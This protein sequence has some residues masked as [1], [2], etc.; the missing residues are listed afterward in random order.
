[1][2][3][4]LIVITGKYASICANEIVVD[5]VCGFVSFVDKEEHYPIVLNT[6]GDYRDFIFDIALEDAHSY[7]PGY[8]DFYSGS[9]FDLSEADF[10]NMRFVGFRTHKVARVVDVVLKNGEMVVNYI[11][12]K[13]DL[14]MN[15]PMLFKS[16]PALAMGVT[17]FSINS[18]SFNLK[19]CE[20]R[21]NEKASVNIKNLSVK[22][23]V[24]KKH[25]GNSYYNLKGIKVLNNRAKGIYVRVNNGFHKRKIILVDN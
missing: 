24:Q 10:D 6:S 9:N 21:F 3:L 25:S 16:E 18:D 2:I 17:V 11:R 22:R 15:H 12:E 14:Y 23:P 1:M 4:I 8:E 13:D 19:E 20:I 5:T 7:L